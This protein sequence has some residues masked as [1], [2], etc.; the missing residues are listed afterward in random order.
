MLP[1]FAV[2]MLT[3]SCRGRRRDLADATEILGIFLSSPVF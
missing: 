2:S 3:S 1:K